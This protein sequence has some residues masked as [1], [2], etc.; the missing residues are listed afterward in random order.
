MIHDTAANNS[1]ESGITTG[2]SVGFKLLLRYEIM[3]RFLLMK[4]DL[5][6]ILYHHIV[7]EISLEQ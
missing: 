5:V 7:A 4:T 2:T 1:K 6:T 3:F